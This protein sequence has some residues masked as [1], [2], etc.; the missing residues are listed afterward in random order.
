MAR[1]TWEREEEAMSYRQPRAGH[2]IRQLGTGAALLLG[3]AGFWGSPMMP[4]R[5]AA[6]QDDLQLGKQ[7]Y[8]EA[9]CVGCHKWHGDGGGGYGGAA[10]SL[11]KTELDRVLLL[12]VVRCGR[13]ATRMPY[14]DRNA[15]QQVECY[16]GTTKAELGADFPP[17]AASFLREE[18]IR[19]VVVYVATRLQGHGEPTKQDCIAFWGEG[20]RECEALP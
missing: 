7:V 20:S 14:H 18:E 9:N 5:P 13:P 15:Y 8:E 6:A 11:R 16:G 10:L 12:E 2:S 3:A 17:K 19:A 1:K 4:A